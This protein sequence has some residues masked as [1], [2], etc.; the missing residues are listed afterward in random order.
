MAVSFLNRKTKFWTDYG[1]PSENSSLSAVRDGV[2][3]R[4]CFGSFLLPHVCC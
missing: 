2:V 3:S 4:I 1:K